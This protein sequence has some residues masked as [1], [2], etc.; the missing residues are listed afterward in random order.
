MSGLRGTD[1]RTDYVGTGRPGLID[2]HS[3]YETGEIDYEMYMSRLEE[4]R[5]FALATKG[6][7]DSAGGRRFRCP[8]KA[9]GSSLSCALVSRGGREAYC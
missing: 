5:R 7:K 6:A 4:R 1:S 8:V 3:A 9:P 2:P